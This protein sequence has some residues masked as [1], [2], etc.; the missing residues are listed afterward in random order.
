MISNF[1]RLASLTT[2][3]TAVTMALSVPAWGLPLSPGDRIRIYIP[4][5][6]EV[7]ETYRIS[8]LYEVNLDGMLQVPLLEPLPV[9]G[10][11]LSAVRQ[12]LTDA[13][14]SGG[15]FLPESLQVSTEVVQWAP[16]QV[17]VAGATFLPGRILVNERA[18][19]DEDNPGLALRPEPFT[20]S[21]DYPPGRYLTAAIREAG[22]LMPTADV[23]NIRLVREGE[24]KIIDL[25]GVFNGEAVE[26]V[27]LVAGDQIVVPQEEF[28]NDLVRPS[29]VTPSAIAVFISNQTE[30]N[31]SGQVTEFAYGSRFSQAVV[32][33]RCAG[34]SQSTNANRRATLVRT[35]RLDGQTEVFDRKV[36]ELLRHSTDNEVNPFL[37]PEDSVVCYDSATTNTSG[38]LNFIGDILNPF[39]LIQSIFF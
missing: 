33:S 31:N 25:S 19:A 13:L 20:V 16:I 35:N 11:E 3:V 2:A 24:E 36:E 4:A 27:A 5:D 15:F 21:G 6:E 10:Q 39:R 29:Q 37:M 14:V 18:T 22:G 23:K 8:G 9:E 38:I 32:L 30:G 28:H 34:G 12:Q 26:D 7:P 1:F 17:T